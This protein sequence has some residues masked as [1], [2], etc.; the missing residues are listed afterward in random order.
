MGDFHVDVGHVDVHVDVPPPHVDVH[1]DASRRRTS[2][3][4]ASIS[5]PRTSTF[6]RRTSISRQFPHRYPDP[7]HR[8][9]AT[10]YRIG[11]VHI[12]LHTDMPTPRH[13]DLPPPPHVDADLPHVDIGY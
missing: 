7:A 8:H 6:R 4:G 1:I 3:L 9:S 10:A 5:R 12:D 11:P 2:T 13:M